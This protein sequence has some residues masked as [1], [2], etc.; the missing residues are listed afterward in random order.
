M[1]AIIQ[2]VTQ[3]NVVVDKEKIS[4]IKDGYLILLAVKETDTDDDL[5]YIQRKISNLRIFEDEEGKL[6]LSL[7]D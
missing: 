6:N 5:D 1:R 4:E 3:A 2:R 7:K